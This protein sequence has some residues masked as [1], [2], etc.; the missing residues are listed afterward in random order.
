MDT[1]IPKPTLLQILR[2]FWSQRKKK[3]YLK[4]KIAYFARGFGTAREV[5]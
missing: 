1:S 5:E 3:L 2:Q 4:R